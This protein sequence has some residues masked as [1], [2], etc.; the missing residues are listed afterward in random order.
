MVEAVQQNPLINHILA[1]RPWLAA[2]PLDFGV[3]QAAENDS[4]SDEAIGNRLI[5]AYRAATSEAPRAERG[6]DM[7]TLIARDWYGDLHA[8][9]ADGDPLRLTAYLKELPRQPAGQGYF[10]GRAAFDRLVEHPDDQNDRALWLMDHL[11]GLAE[12]VGLVDVRCPEQGGWSDFQAL[13][14]GPLRDAIEHEIGLP[15]G[16]PPIFSGLFALESRSRP[17]HLRSVMAAYA[18]WTLRHAMVSLAGK[19]PRE[20]HVAEIGAGIGFTAFAAH[21]AGIGRYAIYDLPD[22]NVAQGYFLLKA[23]PHAAIRLSGE[24]NPDA[25]IAVLHGA[26]FHDTAQAACDLVLNIDSLPEIDPIEAQRYLATA[27]TRAPWLLSINQ[28]SRAMQTADTRQSR[29]RDLVA[30]AGGFRMIQRSPNW[31]RAGYVDEIWTASEGTGARLS[32]S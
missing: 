1:R 21:H 15:V 12:A 29:V 18:I 9:I 31:V 22:V 11:V 28:E 17:I 24:T 19:A 7:W 27:A 2:T 20:L 4:S 8:L 3:T 14:A 16:M 5:A 10:Q 30:R 25:T 6:H 13:S 26:S 23:L 32:T